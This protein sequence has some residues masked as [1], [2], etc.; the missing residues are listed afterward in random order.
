MDLFPDLK[1]TSPEAIAHGAQCRQAHDQEQQNLAGI[2]AATPGA[3]P[4]ISVP[5]APGVLANYEDILV[6]EKISM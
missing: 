4:R 5:W 6:S 2:A 3:D 1:T